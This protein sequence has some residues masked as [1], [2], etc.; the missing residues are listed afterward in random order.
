MVGV[1]W[2]KHLAIL[3]LQRD[4]A[5]NGLAPTDRLRYYSAGQ[6]AG[7]RRRGIF[8]PN[9]WHIFLIKKSIDTESLFR[10]ISGLPRV[11]Y[12][13]SFGLFQNELFIIIQKKLQK[14]N[15]IY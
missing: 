15:N 13:L 3:L 8:R 7:K 1:I 9:A 10:L 5:E 14:F 12:F 6:A 2:P 11:N 4:V